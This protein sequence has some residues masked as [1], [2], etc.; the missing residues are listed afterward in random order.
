MAIVSFI[1]GVIF[2]F[3]AFRQM[4]AQDRAKGRRRLNKIL[5]DF[6]GG[7]FEEGVKSSLWQYVHGMLLHIFF[8]F[9]LIAITAAIK[10]YA[11]K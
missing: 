2:F 8:F 1:I 3:L 10:L 11:E 7:S 6:G 4:D 9:F 5:T